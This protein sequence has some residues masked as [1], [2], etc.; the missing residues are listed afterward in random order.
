MSY[1][2]NRA[3]ILIEV[4]PGEEKEFTKYVK[5][6]GLLKETNLE[7][8]DSVHGSFDVVITLRGTMKSIDAR[9]MELRKSP[10]IRRTTTLVCAEMLDWEDI[11][12]P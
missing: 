10:S 3:Y 8:M 4:E 12:D 11:R 7:R 1:E 5:S 2:D 9:I 6:K